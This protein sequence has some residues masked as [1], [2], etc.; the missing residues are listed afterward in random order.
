M[1]LL[2]KLSRGE[3]CHTNFTHPCDWCELEYLFPDKSV[4]SAIKDKDNLGQN[5][6]TDRQIL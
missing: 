1:L 2:I 6:Q 4:I 3:I 5:R